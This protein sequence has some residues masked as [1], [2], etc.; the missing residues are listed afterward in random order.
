MTTTPDPVDR[1]REGI[2]RALAMLRADPSAV[3]EMLH[4]HARIE[5]IAWR[6]WRTIQKI[7]GCTMDAGMLV[8]AIERGEP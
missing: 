8:R 1:L 5:A 3:D 4:E 6:R 2:R 7:G